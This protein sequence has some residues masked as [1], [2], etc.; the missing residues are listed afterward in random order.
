M[1]K[2]YG[3]LEKQDYELRFGTGISVLTSE[4]ENV[5]SVKYFSQKRYSQKFHIY[6]LILYQK[7]I[8]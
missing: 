5:S 7:I 6:L 3:V 2:P 1:G 4:R 8:K